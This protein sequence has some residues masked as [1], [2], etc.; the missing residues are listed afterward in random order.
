M[1]AFVGRD[2]DPI[3]KECPRKVLMLAETRNDIASEIHRVQFDMGQ[4][5][6][7]GDPTFDTAVNAPPRDLAGCKKKWPVRAAWAARRNSA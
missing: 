3:D 5:V 4:G 7:K 6:E 1:S 2:A